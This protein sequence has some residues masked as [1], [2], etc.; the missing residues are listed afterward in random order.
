MFDSLNEAGWEIGDEN[1]GQ[2]IAKSEFREE[3]EKLV[4]LL[5]DW[6]LDLESNIIKRG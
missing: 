2:L 3:C 5:S 6:S 1:H 4:A